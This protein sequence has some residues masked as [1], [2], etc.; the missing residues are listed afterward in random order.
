MGSISHST[1]SIING[2]CKVEHEWL[3]EQAVFTIWD[4]SAIVIEL[5]I[6]D[7][8]FDC[9]LAAVDAAAKQRQRDIAALEA[10]E[11]DQV[12]IEFSS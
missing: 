12:C 5:Y 8:G 3:G 11:A 9:L 4:G 6:D 2:S 10:E 1:L 7:D